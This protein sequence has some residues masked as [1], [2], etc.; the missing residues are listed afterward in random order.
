MG[1][2]WILLGLSI[3]S[4]WVFLRNERVVACVTCNR[5]VVCRNGRVRADRGLV[6]IRRVLFL[7]DHAN[8]DWARWLRSV[9]HLKMTDFLLN[10]RIWCWKWWILCC[11]WRIYA[12]K[13]W[14]LCCNWRIYAEKWWTRAP[15]TVPETKGGVYFNIVYCVIGLGLIGLLITA[16]GGA[17]FVVLLI[18]VLNVQRWWWIFPEKWWFSLVLYWKCRDNGDLP[19]KN[20]Y[21]FIA[22]SLAAMH[23]VRGLCNDNAALDWQWQA[24]LMLK[25]SPV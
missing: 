4:Q 7:R 10:W 24:V 9:C 23:E 1:V 6:R 19:L 18:F 22:D 8:D 5:F 2:G 3:V 17:I 13:W 14:I 16:V 20:D 25:M 21:L 12:E 11:N 15:A